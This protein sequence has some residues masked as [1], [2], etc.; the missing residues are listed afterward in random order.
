MLQRHFV[1][2]FG[3]AFLSCSAPPSDTPDGGPP[4]DA[5][6]TSDGGAD[7][8]SD[9]GAL[10]ACGLS[11]CTVQE[12]CVVSS[13]VFKTCFPPD[14]GG[15]PVGTTFGACSGGPTNRGCFTL[16]QPEVPFCAPRSSAECD[17]GPCAACPSSASGTLR[18]SYLTCEC[19]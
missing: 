12:V 5:G 8:G 1:V 6:V 9:G 10:L 19:T 17:G 14:A 11:Q 4:T 3:F 13:R 2:F 18:G 16:C 15:C 7:A